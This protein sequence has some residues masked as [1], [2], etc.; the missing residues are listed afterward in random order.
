M[1]IV[2]PKSRV[3]WF[4][5][6]EVVDADRTH[7]TGLVA[8]VVEKYPHDYGEVASLFYLCRETKVN[9]PSPQ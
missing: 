3:W 1:R 4:S 2:A 7:F 9:I 5:L 8:D 6:N